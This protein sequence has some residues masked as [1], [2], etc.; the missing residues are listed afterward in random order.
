MY[1]YAL[2]DTYIA[3]TSHLCL[4][5][6]GK[7][8]WLTETL[9]SPIGPWTDWNIPPLDS[10]DMPSEMDISFGKPGNPKNVGFTR[11]FTRVFIGIIV[12][13]GEGKHS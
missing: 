9:T 1:I 7:D 12:F 10:L 4:T 8:T 11:V 6:A 13:L 3:F 2:R 5:F